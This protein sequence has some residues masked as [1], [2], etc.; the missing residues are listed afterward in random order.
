MN[1]A[2]ESSCISSSKNDCK[3]DPSVPGFASTKLGTINDRQMVF[4]VPSD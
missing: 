4:G 1:I 2:K 3:T